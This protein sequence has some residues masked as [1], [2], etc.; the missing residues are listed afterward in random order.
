LY[1]RWNCK[2]GESGYISVD[3]GDDPRFDLLQGYFLMSELTSWESLAQNTVVSIW[4][5]EVHISC[6]YVNFLKS[7]DMICISQIFGD[8]QDFTSIAETFMS[9]FSEITTICGGAPSNAEVWI[10]V[11]N[12]HYGHGLACQLKIWYAKSWLDCS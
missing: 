4:N 11:C 8:I 6:Q 2:G 10:K 3:L 1:E 9:G 7:L 5:R 12:S